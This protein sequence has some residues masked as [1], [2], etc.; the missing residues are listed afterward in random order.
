M[1][2]AGKG[3][4]AVEISPCNGKKASLGFSRSNGKGLTVPAEKGKSFSYSGSKGF[5]DQGR[6]GIMCAI[7][8]ITKK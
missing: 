3:A 4:I 8:A 7:K 6:E 2:V 5:V 1:H